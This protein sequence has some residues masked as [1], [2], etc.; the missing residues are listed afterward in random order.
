MRYILRHLDDPIMLQRSP[1]AGLV[2]VGKRAGESYPNQLVSRG[3]AL[4]DLVIEWLG[5]V[6]CSV[7][8]STSLKHFHDY[9]VFTRKGMGTVEASKNLRLS[10][11]HV[12]RTYKKM[13]VQLLVER[14][15]GSPQQ[16]SG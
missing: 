2:M 16:E 14:I 6:E 13:L 12:S 15:T 3:R 10:A 5:E 7:E 8:E 11:E 1:V 4:H 9:V